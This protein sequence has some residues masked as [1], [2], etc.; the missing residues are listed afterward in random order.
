VGAW[1]IC[2]KNV[3]LIAKKR[4]DIDYYTDT[5]FTFAR[6]MAHV[7]FDKLESDDPT[8]IAKLRAEIAGHTLIGEYIGSVE[9]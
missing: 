7:W 8:L 9:H 3:A 6:E 4:S 1:V 5:R 2:S